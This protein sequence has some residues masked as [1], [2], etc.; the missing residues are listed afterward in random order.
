MNIGIVG[1]GVVGSACKY[2]FA[3]M[4]HKV[5]SHDIS[6]ETSLFDVIDSEI[7]YICVPTPPNLEGGCDTT[8]V[9]SVIQELLD[10]DYG[11]HITIKSTVIPGTTK[12]LSKKYGV[13]LCF[14][15]EFLRE[16]CAVSDFTENHDL[17]AVGCN[18]DEQFEAIVRSHG[19]LPKKIRK[20]SPS[21]A[22]LL[23]YYS[24]TFNAMKVVF[25]NTMYEISNSLGAD[26]HAVKEAF[27][28]RETASDMY[29]DVNENFRGYGGVCLPKD[30]AA[31]AALVKELGLDM[32][33]FETIEKENKKFKTTVYEGMRQQ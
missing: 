18:G 4:G 20:L 17:L 7:C 14:V 10:M 11:G 21:E 32:N 9:E 22:E 24:N 28:Q 12:R 30:T 2:G 5:F 6:L 25:A 15:P 3:K 19:N 26:Y 33:L 31:M 29:L 1:L 16:R 8:I 27:I 23:K 13:S